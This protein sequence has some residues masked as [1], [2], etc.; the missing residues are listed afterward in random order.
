[1]NHGHC[2]G[3]VLTSLPTGHDWEFGSS[4]YGLEPLTLPNAREPDRQPP[5]PEPE[6]M[7]DACQLIRLIGG[8]SEPSS[9]VKPCPAAD[10]LFWFRWITGHQVS[11]I[12]WRLMAQLVTDT[13]HGWLG[14]ETALDRLSG[15]IRAYC[16]MLLYTGSCPRVV[17]QEVIRP[18]MRL[19]HRSFSGSW[20]PDFWAVR[21]LL[22]ARRF[23]F[24][25]AEESAGL[26]EVIRLQ[27][28]VHDG[29]AAKLVPDGRSLLRQAGVRGL[30]AR[31]LNVIYD[32]YFLTLRA[33]VSRHDVVA[34][35]LR[36]LVAIAQDLAV[37]QLHPEGMTQSVDL[38]EELA[39]SEVISCENDLTGILF[40]TA[41]CAVD[42]PGHDLELACPRPAVAR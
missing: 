34:Q 17:Y 15:Y 12:V 27:Q 22:R 25:A 16:A 5:V 23:P 2:D 30:D 9:G 14:R 19:Q 41:C 13:E 28:L 1:M 39:A 21:D 3:L 26:R 10:E 18:S 4:P 11:F 8:R 35:L 20:A 42:P 38:P 37:N 29:V 33:P 36:R 31:L 32:N 6:P 40:R 7:G 24:A